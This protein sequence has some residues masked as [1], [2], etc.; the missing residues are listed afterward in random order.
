[1]ACCRRRMAR[2]SCATPSPGC[3][4]VIRRRRWASAVRTLTPSLWRTT[5]NVATAAA[6]DHLRRL[7]PRKCGGQGGQHSGTRAAACRGSPEEVD[8]FALLA[9]VDSEI[10]VLNRPSAQIQSD[11]ALGVPLPHKTRAPTLP[12]CRDD[13]HWIAIIA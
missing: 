6:V 1:M 12:T 3:S 9:A 7:S 5:Q 2:P 4:G 10:P 8:V 11:G 13:N